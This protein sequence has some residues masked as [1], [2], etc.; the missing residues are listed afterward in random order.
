M[1][2]S[3]GT[4]DPKAAEAGKAEA[5]AEAS[6]VEAAG[7]PDS[8]VEASQPESAEAPAPPAGGQDAPDAEA[9]EADP[10]VP[11]SQTVKV[12]LMLRATA[13]RPEDGA[14]FEPQHVE[15]AEDVPAHWRLELPRPPEGS[16]GVVYFIEAA[17][18]KRFQ[19]ALRRDAPEQLGVALRR[20]V[21]RGAPAPAAPTAEAKKAVEDHAKAVAEAIAGAADKRGTPGFRKSPQPEKVPDIKLTARQY[22][23]ARNIRFTDAAGF[24]YEMRTKH[25]VGAKKTR[26]EWKQLHREFQNRPVK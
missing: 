22:C 12:Q 17:H 24:L 1:A 21:R 2:K 13:L 5:A 6:A 19:L 4:R 18:H 23:R 11:L 3:R 14:R 8:P 26:P 9:V 16:R 20:L 25:G 7:A 15:A 10:A